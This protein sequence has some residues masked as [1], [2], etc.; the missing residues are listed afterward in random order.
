MLQFENFNHRY[1]ENERRYRK[2]FLNVLVFFWADIPRSVIKS[3]SHGN[4][5][6]VG[7]SS[8]IER[9]SALLLHS[10]YVCIYVHVFREQ[11]FCS[12]SAESQGWDGCVWDS[13]SI[14]NHP[15]CLQPSPTGD[16]LGITSQGGFAFK[17]S[18]FYPFLLSSFVLHW[19]VFFN[20]EE[21]VR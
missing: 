2:L 17:H 18:C 16:H 15:P 1:F 12:S 8:F 10:Y 14:K 11:N 19:L 6:R 4:R 9:T 5:N 21:T 3:R 13:Q 20:L 7:I